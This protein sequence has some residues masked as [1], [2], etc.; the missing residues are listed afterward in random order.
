M[1]LGQEMF[2]EIWTMHASQIGDEWHTMDS[3]VVAH[4][5]ASWPCTFLLEYVVGVQAR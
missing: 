1:R 2:D 4:G 3:R 5:S